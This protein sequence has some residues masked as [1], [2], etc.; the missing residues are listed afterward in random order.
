MYGLIFTFNLILILGNYLIMAFVNS[1][2]LTMKLMIGYSAVLVLMAQI[3]HFKIKEM[4]HG[5]DID[6][7]F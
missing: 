1:R 2:T 6:L 5:F 3:Y 4:M 7:V